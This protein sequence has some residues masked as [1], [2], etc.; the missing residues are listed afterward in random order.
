VADELDI[1]ISYKSENANAVRS[2]VEELVARGVRVWFD[3]YEIRTDTGDSW[4]N[5]VKPVI[6]AGIDRSNYFL[7]FTNDR[8]AESDYCND[9]I[10]RIKVKGMDRVLEIRIPK[11]EGVY[12]RH[13]ELL[14][15]RGSID[16]QGEIG[17]VLSFIR[18]YFADLELAEQ[19]PAEP[20]T[21]TDQ[22]IEPLRFGISMQAGPLQ[23]VPATT[24]VHE[25]QRTRPWVKGET[26]LFEGL[27][28]GN[29]TRM[30]VSINPFE[31]AVGNLSVREDIAADDHAVRRQYRRFA[32]DWLERHGLSEL[33]VHLFFWNGHS[34]LAITYTD[35]NAEEAHTWERRYAIVVRDSD[36]TD[37]GE[38]DITFS[39]PFGEEAETRQD[40]REAFARFAPQFDS[41]AASLAYEPER[42]LSSE[43]YRLVTSKV[44]L[45]LMGLV[46][47]AASTMTAQSVIIQS[48]AAAIVGI[49][50]AEL[51]TAI[52]SHRARRLALQAVL[53]TSP[54]RTSPVRGREA[55]YERE[56]W[57]VGVL[58]ALMATGAGLVELPGLLF[59]GLGLALKVTA[60]WYWLI[61]GAVLA[62]CG[63]SGRLAAVPP[64]VGGYRQLKQWAPG[65]PRIHPDASL[66][67]LSPELRPVLAKLRRHDRRFLSRVGKWIL[68]GLALAVG[69]ALSGYGVAGPAVLLLA[70]G[71]GLSI[72]L[73]ESRRARLPGTETASADY[74]RSPDSAQARCISEAYLHSDALEVPRRHLSLALQWAARAWQLDPGGSYES[75]ISAAAA[76]TRITLKPTVAARR[77]IDFAQRVCRLARDALD[78]AGRLARVG[79][80][81]ERV[82]ALRNELDEVSQKPDQL[83]TADPNQV[84]SEVE[85]S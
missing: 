9:E 44:Q 18:E 46:G 20:A 75:A 49:L 14:A 27:I 7:V 82:E 83:S 76:A 23:H 39:V 48:A 37:L 51:I 1:F 6:F 53:Q 36:G 59:V 74:T 47:L 35:P 33:G 21:I 81:R 60:P 70:T 2:V 84:K 38:V 28:A 68:S 73:S 43:A 52:I 85:D 56:R 22:M 12:Q 31:T 3:E 62:G 42:S 15:A 30:E 41:F 78:V 13:P 58:M 25:H 50:S 63:L 19:P 5:D 69:L 65:S 24:G 11:E 34:H 80:E 26:Y 79:S 67:A 64:E 29:P 45:V 4:R 71:A 55:S 61:A 16:W 10:E 77:E 66:N 8:W 17:S 72:F 54:L 32:R 57:L 40:E